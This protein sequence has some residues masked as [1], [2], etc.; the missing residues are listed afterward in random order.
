MNSPSEQ[1][2][3]LAFKAR[4][5]AA[6]SS[7]PQVKLRYLRSA[8]HFDNLVADLENIAHAKARNEAARAEAI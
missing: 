2:R 4:Q 7:L 5:Q 1:Y 8:E 6:A 3:E